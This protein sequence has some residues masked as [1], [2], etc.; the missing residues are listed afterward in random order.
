[1]L[2]RLETLGFRNLSHQSLAPHPRFNL[3]RGE[4]AQ[5]KTNLL[6]AVSV[7]STLRS[8]RAR[9]VEELLRFGEARARLRGAVREG[10]ERSELEVTLRPGGRQA[11]LSGKVPRETTE[12][13]RCFPTVLFW[14]EELAVPRGSPAER[15]RLL[16]SAVA[17]VWP[18]FLPLSRDYQRALLSRNRILHDPPS[19]SGS[20]LSEVYERQLA[21]LGGKLIAA[22]VR[23]LRGFGPVFARVFREISRSGAEGALH[24]R[25]REELEAAGDSVAGLGEA[26]LRLYRD[27]RG[28]DQARKATSVGPHA[29]DLEFQIDGRRARSFGSQGQLR[30]LVLAF[31]IAQ[32]LDGHEKL[33]RYP[34]LLL[35]DVSSELD[36]KRNSY[37]F[38]FIKSI[39]A[40]TFLTTT[41]VSGL[42]VPKERLDFQVVSGNI[43]PL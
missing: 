27:T 7:L 2:E 24:Y 13:L 25:G 37:L 39:D 28:V 30:S 33:G 17:T 3:I 22:R 38:E 21:E 40:Q 19:R 5:G 4:N 14:P 1:V 12:Y 41:L 35:D 36:P 29:D 31:K 23:F 6:E 26:L 8:F 11:R 18:G 32:I 42:P 15:R 10:E 20:T 9:R 43:T 34:V 16:D